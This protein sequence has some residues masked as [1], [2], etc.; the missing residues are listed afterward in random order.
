[1][2]GGTVVVLGVIVV[3][4]TFVVV[5]TGRTVHALIIERHIQPSIHIFK[6]QTGRKHKK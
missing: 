2:V 1:V 3:V 5:E 4:L 6:E